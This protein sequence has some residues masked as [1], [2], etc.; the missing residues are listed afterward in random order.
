MTTRRSS[1][2]ASPFE[3][4]FGYAR[5]VRVGNLIHVS[6]TAAIEPDGSVTPGGAGPQTE[7]CL[8][9]IA[10][11]LT[12]L[13]SSLGD[14]VRTRIFITDITQYP[15]VGEAHHAAFADVRPAA[16][17]VEVSALIHP[18]MIVEIEADVV[19]D[20]AD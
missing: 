15:A 4:Q 9:I 7:R 1:Q 10:S 3:T 17:M 18:D 5:A 13:G 8:A 20:A 2:S 11:A 14:V 12:E 16:T 19:I 6:G